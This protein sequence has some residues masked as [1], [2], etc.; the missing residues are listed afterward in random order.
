MCGITGIYA[1]NEVGRLN[2]INLAAATDRL[3]QR[4][5]DQQGTFVSHFIGLGHRRL[6]ILDLSDKG[7]QPMQDAEGRHIIV[8]NGEIY[9][10][11]ALRK[12]LENKGYH[13]K[14][15]TD[16]E[17]LLNLYI[18]MGSSCLA[19][20]NGFFAFAILD[21]NENSLFIARDRIGIKPLY[22]YQDEDKFLF[23]SELK[24]LL[25]YGINKALDLASLCHYFQLNYI[26]APHSIFSQV[27][28]VLPGHYIVVQNNYVEQRKYYTIPYEK[29][30]KA[31]SG[32]SYE[33][34]Q[35]QL[36][37][38]LE[39]SVTRRLVADVPIGAFLSGG[40][41]SSII[42]AIA[43]KHTPHLNTF[44]IGFT[45]E[46][47]FDETKYAH[48]VAK[49]FNTEHT[50]FSLTNKDLLEHLTDILTYMDE[51]FADSSAIPVYILSKYT[52]E[53][54]T[55]ALSGDGADELFAGYNKHAAFFKAKQGGMAVE[56]IRKLLPL[57]KLMPKS[58]NGVLSNK[59]RQLER[60]AKGMN[61]D[62]QQ[63][64]WIWAS[65]SSQKEAMNLLNENLIT[66]IALEEVESRTAAFT[67]HI[68]IDYDIND[69]LFADMQLVLPNDMLTKVD[70]MSMAN[71]LEVRVPFLDHE[72]VKFAFQLPEHTKINKGM[73]KR[74]L[75]DAYKT[76]LPPELYNRPKHGFEVPLLK[77]FR[78]E[79]KD[80][81]Q[82]DL[83]ND[84]FVKEQG[85]FN[86]HAIKKLKR[87][88]YAANPGDVHAR[89]W[90]LI[91]FQFWW[92]KNMG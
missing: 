48:I 71:G 72:L 88:L 87:Q 5:P 69:L 27:K 31:I 24:S 41:D 51:P 79:L 45:D 22:Y 9:N 47:F 49:K 35:S 7:K 46:P 12:R 25:A 82:N 23:A 56:T 30:E 83:L 85:I 86:P 64:Y 40:I 68:P 38:L 80:L 16:T 89:I 33:D 11:A 17:V 15:E 73:K 39:E 60:F 65:I 3:Q 59:V 52:K 92:K 84:S 77:W 1:F 42:T 34:Q 32:L 55:V 74:I 26:P 61:M 44:S 19:L 53:K 78:N 91:V 81:I 2:M 58:R 10:Y 21:K 6:S 66:K 75:Q 28:K 57:W 62:I 18:E 20:L 36:K 54:A 43:S 70:M 90:A 50:T 29:G 13:F 67:S 76:E 4:G 37:T 63:R 14:T 8:F